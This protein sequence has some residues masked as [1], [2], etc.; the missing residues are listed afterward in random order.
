LFSILNKSRS[1]LK[2]VD[3]GGKE[4][5]KSSSSGD[6]DNDYN[7]EQKNVRSLRIVD[8]TEQRAQNINLNRRTTG[9]ETPDYTENTPNNV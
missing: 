8:Q 6:E 3:V 4:I 1:R 5:K 2:I 7:D 9:V